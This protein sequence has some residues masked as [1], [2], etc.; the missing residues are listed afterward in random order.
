MLKKTLRISFIAAILYSSAAHADALAQRAAVQFSSELDA[1]NSV[2]VYFL[3]RTEDYDLGK[4]DFKDKSAIRIFRK[5]GS[6]C[7]NF[8]KLFVDHLRDSMSVK[9]KSGQQDILLEFGKD[10]TAYYSY[11]GRIVEFHDECYMNANSLV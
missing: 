6:N 7:S 9:C 2:S 4:D 5:C 11:S 8:M 3:S 1:V 10:G